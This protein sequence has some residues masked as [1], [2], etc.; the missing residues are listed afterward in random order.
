MI[1]TKSM[2]FSLQMHSKAPPSLRGKYVLKWVDV[3]F[4]LLHVFAT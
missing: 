2:E 4:A 3:S 1:G